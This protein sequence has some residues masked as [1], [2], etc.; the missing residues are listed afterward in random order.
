MGKQIVHS[1]VERGGEARSHHIANISKAL[2]P[3]V[4]THVSR[5]SK[6]QG[7]LFNGENEKASGMS[8]RISGVRLARRFSFSPEDL[9]VLQEVMPVDMAEALEE[10]DW[11]AV[12]RDPLGKPRGVVDFEPK[13]K[14][15]LLHTKGRAKT[16]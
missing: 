7:N 4:V 12:L 16:L 15:A 11:N 13:K 1:L 3:L 2:R 10:V 9:K 14:A 5:K 6:K 8:R